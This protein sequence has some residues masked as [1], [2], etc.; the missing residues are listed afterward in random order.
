M[1]EGFYI[2]V[3]FNYFITLHQEQKAK[4]NNKHKEMSF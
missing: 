3:P 4:T 1:V 2:I